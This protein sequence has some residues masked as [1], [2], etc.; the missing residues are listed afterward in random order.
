MKTIKVSDITIK[1][2]GKS[3][4]YSLSFREK[5]E[6]AKLLEKLNVDV[7]ELSPIENAMADTLLIKSISSSV[8]GSTIAVPVGLSVDGIDAVWKGLS[9]AAKPRLQIEVPVSDAQM[10]YIARKKPDAMIKLVEELVTYS[11]ALCSDVEF[12]AVD[13]TRC[14]FDFLIKAIQTAISAGAS[15]VTVCDT[16]GTMLADEFGE[17]IKELYNALPELSEVCLGVECANN[18][19]VAD[20]AIITAVAEGADE[21]KAGVYQSNTASFKNIVN[22]L[23]EKSEVIGAASRIKTTNLKRIFDQIN[24]MCETTRSA[25]SPFDNGVQANDDSFLTY[26][27]TIQAVSLA[28]KSLGYDLSSEDEVNVF[29][30]FTKIAHKKEQVKVK[31]LDAIVA[32]VALQVPPTYRVDSY[33]ITTGNKISATAHLKLL[34]NGEALEGISL[35]DGPIDAAFIAIEQII[36][37]HF[38]LDDFQIKA[39]TQGREAT[40]QAVV[41]LCSEGKLYSGRGISTDIVGASINAYV[42]ALNKIVYEQGEG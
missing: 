26:N 37:R 24:R 9:N 34:K 3:G 40:G 30:A 7:I 6:I 32:S 5:I 21:I 41:K 22:I 31:E 16:A 15:T 14:N 1:Q 38:E 8:S 4:G 17:F 29:D 25:H 13:A 39:I 33:V 27:D 2:S 12:I 11:K 28:V 36:G 19:S 42:S 35:G 20:S 18:L 23:S 10:E